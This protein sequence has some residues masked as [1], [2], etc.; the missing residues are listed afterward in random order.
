M[1]DDA[2]DLQQAIE[3]YEKQLSQVQSALAVSPP[4]AERD[5]LV[6][7][8]ADIEEL[9]TLSKK[10]LSAL[11]NHAS[12]SQ[13]PV[14]QLDK[15]YAL[16]KAE[17]EEAEGKTN[18]ESL[19]TETTTNIEEELSALQ[20]MK[21]QAPHKHGWGEVSYHNALVC[22]AQVCDGGSTMDDIQVRIMFTNPTHRDMLPC[23]YYLEGECRFSDEQCHFSHGES[24]RL[25]D[26]KEYKEPNF[27]AVRPGLRILVLQE[28][29]LWHRGVVLTSTGQNKYQVKLESSGKKTDVDL[30]HILPLDDED[31]SSSDSESDDDVVIPAEIVEK[32]LTNVPL[33]AALGEWEKHTKGIGSR[34]MAQM[35]YVTGTGLGRHGEGRIEPVEVMIFPAG[36]SL[37]HCMELR[38]NAGGDM[39]LFKA[40]KR[41][42]RLQ[43]KHQQQSERQYQRDKQQTRVFDFIN[44][45]LNNQKQN[46]QSSSSADNKGLKSE[47]NKSLNM[48]G[49]LV[50]EDICRAEK[51]LAKLQQSLSRHAVG[52]K[53]HTIIASKVEDKQRELTRL[54]TSEM[55]I[56]QEKNQRKDRKKLSVF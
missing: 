44:S 40:E 49:Y 51:D 13:D 53:T 33:N 41:L 48:V 15:E 35:G 50:G 2:R 20:G 56:N 45:K 9:I 18:S 54:R 39:D 21:C 14:D 6:S 52:S 1:T 42:K 32:S 38:E 29:K 19:P 7:L 12:S 46:A 31:T 55:S 26:L 10:N 28:D 8:K 25:S 24:V 27:S 47:T 17:L 37:D 11:E 36:K 30:Q 3:Q 43:K 22:G 23:P 16:F 4:G 34:L 5:S